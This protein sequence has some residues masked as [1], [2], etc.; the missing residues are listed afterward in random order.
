VLVDVR[1]LQDGTRRLSRVL[2]EAG[3]ALTEI[4]TDGR[5][6]RFS[7][8]TM[9]IDVLA[10]DGLGPRADVTTV[11]P[12]RTIPVPGGSPALD[13]TERVDVEIAATT[14][15]LPRTNLLG[16]L[17]I[18][19]RAVDVDD[20][21]ENQRRDVAF[22]LSPVDDPRELA[23]QRRR[24]ERVPLRRRAELFDPGQLAWSGGENAEDA[25]LALRI[26]GG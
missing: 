10:P 16:A 14:G 1:V 26:L 15:V 6:H 22:L 19:W 9:L 4:T 8:R 5:G 12:A 17:L 25:R 7:D 20:A 24:G 13:R 18:E 23:G 3:F 11:P 21:P 2:Q